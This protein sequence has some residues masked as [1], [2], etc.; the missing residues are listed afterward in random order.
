[1]HGKALAT[2]A[3]RGVDQ[4]AVRS[5]G[6]GK[7]ALLNETAVNGVGNTLAMEMVTAKIIVKEAIAEAAIPNTACKHSDGE[8][9][10]G[11]IG[12]LN[13]RYSTAGGGRNVRGNPDGCLGSLA[14]NLKITKK[15]RPAISILRSKD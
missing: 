11:E 4:D 15:A 2:L 13:T 12:E 7:G 8:I 6:S 14:N 5:A 3:V 1:M 9:L 10:Y